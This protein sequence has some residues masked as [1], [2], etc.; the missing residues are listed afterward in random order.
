MRDSPWTMARSRSKASPKASGPGPVLLLGAGTGEATCGILYLASYLRRHGVEAT[1]RLTDADASEAELKRS[2]GALLRH[3]RPRLVGISLK[4]FHHLARALRVARTV[5]AIDPD[6]RIVLGGNTASYFWRELAAQDGVDDVVLGDGEAP[7]LALAQGKPSPPNVVTSGQTIRP[8]LGYVQ[9]PSSDDVHYSHFEQLFASG[10]D[11]ASFSGWVAPGKGCGENCVY[12]GGG[13]G[14]QQA[15]FGRAK[16]FLRPDAAVHRDHREIAPHTWQLRYDF[17]GA[18]GAFLERAWHGLDFS[19][20]STTYFLWGVPPRDLVDALARNFR[21]TF[22]VLDVGCFSEAQRLGLIRQGLL[23]PCPTDAQ[24]LDVVRDCRRHPNLQ[25]EVSGI[26]GLPGATPATLRQERDLVDRLLE[27]GCAVGYQRLECQPGALVT[28]HPERFG[29][30]S[31]ART[32][33]EFLDYFEARGVNGDGTVPM[34]RF[35]DRKLEAAVQRASD[36]V[37]QRVWKAAERRAEVRLGERT[38]LVRSSVLRASTLGEWLGA[39]RVPPTLAAEPVTVVRG[40]DG[41]G[42]ACAPTVDA[43]RFEDPSLQ[44]GPEAAALLAALE[45]CARPVTLDAAVRDLRARLGLEPGAARELF[46][47]LVQGRFLV[48]A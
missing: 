39:H 3:L 8:A 2:L 25:L 11:L 7:L 23:K 45:A 22:M 41:A 21:R 24:L 14:V 1:V 48:P 43:R 28:E 37:D 6:V 12:C 17:A 36:A 27:Q 42:L 38:R 18:S 16:P 26:A 33:Q 29:M 40:D 31:E 44:Q 5:R 34:V 9:G 32:F 15:S 46:A 4:W 19:Q 35:A 47:Q 30:V 10:A 13:R 20:H